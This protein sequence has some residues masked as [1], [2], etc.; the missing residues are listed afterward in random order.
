MLQ[1]T[2]YLDA[3]D[4]RAVVVMNKYSKLQ[5]DRGHSCLILLYPGAKPNI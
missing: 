5:F 4:V 3:W 1:W 2:D